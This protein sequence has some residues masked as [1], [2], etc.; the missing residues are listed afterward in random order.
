MASPVQYSHARGFPTLQIVCETFAGA[1]N[2]VTGAITT[3]VV[4]LHDVL[5]PSPST[6][7]ATK[8]SVVDRALIRENEGG[9]FPEVI[10]TRRKR[11]RVSE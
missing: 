4:I 6:S 2:D 11:V 5:R 9:E 3:G 8:T 10:E 1:L 7:A